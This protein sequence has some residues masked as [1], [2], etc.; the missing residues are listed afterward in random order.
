MCPH[1]R[2]I[3]QACPHCN[4]LNAMNPDPNRELIDELAELLYDVPILHDENSDTYYQLIEGEEDIEPVW[5][6]KKFN[7]IIHLFK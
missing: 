5:I 3:W 4:G 7:S 2:D 1:G 6:D